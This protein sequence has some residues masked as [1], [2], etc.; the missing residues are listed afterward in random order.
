MVVDLLSIQGRERQVRESLPVVMLGDSVPA[1]RLQK[2]VEYL[3]SIESHVLI[4][5]E[6]GTQPEEI[7]KYL[8]SCS[9]RR[10]EP[11]AQV[12]C[13]ATPPDVLERWLFGERK[14][15]F[16]DAYYDR[17]GQVE[18]LDGGALML[19]GIEELSPSLQAKVLRFGR[20]GEFVRAGGEEIRYSGARLFCQ[21]GD[22]LRTRVEE[23]YFRADLYFLLR[24]HQ[25]RVPPL[26]DRLE[27]LPEIVQHLVR[28]NGHA[29]GVES[30]VLD[31]LRMHDW[32]GNVQELQAV[33][34]EAM[35]FSGGRVIRM[36]HLPEAYGKSETGSFPSLQENERQHIERV[37]R[38][39][40]FNKSRAAKIL[41]I[42]RPT[43][44]NK[45]F[46][47]GLFDG[48]EIA[49]PSGAV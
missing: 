9:S 6:A 44:N 43:L 21:A 40:G 30:A 23:G 3:A 22:D 7:A 14:L 16:N 27:D 45:I 47:Y 15:V 11:L 10:D 18:E 24:Q 41:R 46:R 26:R 33:I 39:T 4:L 1:R 12:D 20:S 2:L 25:L 19:I 36:E 35:I 8:H 31:T 34:E 42:S 13:R 38:H 28:S 37:L 5:G 32:P 29:A 48:R 17:S 49:G